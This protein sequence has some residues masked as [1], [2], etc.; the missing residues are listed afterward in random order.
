MHESWSDGERSQTKVP[1]GT[2][3]LYGLRDSM[4]VEQ[5][6]IEIKAYNEKR[7]TKIRSD[8]SQYKALKRL[9]DMRRV[10]KNL[11]PPDLIIDFAND[12]V[13]GSDGQERYKKRLQA[14]ILHD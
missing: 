13:S 11:F 10:D 1:E 5:A 7:K 3:Y 12:L 4:S 6:R 14:T 9:Q 8:V 2:Y